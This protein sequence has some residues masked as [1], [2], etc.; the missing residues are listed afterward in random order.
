MT[1]ISVESPSSEVQKGLKGVVACTTSLSYIDGDAGKL[2]YLGY[3]IED[4][5]R[6]ATYEEVAYL[7]WYG[8]LPTAA[9]LADLRARLVAEMPLPQDVLDAIARTPKHA[10]PITVLRTMVSMLS[11]YDPRPDDNSEQENL[12]KAISITARMPM[13]TAAFLRARQGLAPVAPR[14]DLGFTANF[15]YCLNGTVPTPEMVRAI[16]MYLVLLADHGLNA[17][18]FAS[19]VTISTNSDMF[20]AITSAIGTLKGPLHG[21]ANRAA[22]EMIEKLSSPEE[23]RQFI[24]DALARKERIMGFG[25]RVYKT[26]DPRGTLLYDV[27]VDLLESSGEQNLLHICQ[28]IEEEMMKQKGL[29]YNVDF[30]S[31]PVLDKTGFP[32]D[33]FVDVFAIS[34]GAGWTAHVIEFMRDPA[35]MR[36]RAKY[37]GPM[38]A[39]WVPIE[40]RR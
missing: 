24:T 21:G 30:Y 7:L 17:S 6:H 19:I 38:A 15:L 34:R 31:A 40:E 8:K 9:E 5:A 33:A 37:V 35:L 4:L 3:T 1:K 39:T 27:A 22:Q 23:A 28:A 32:T 13:I 11:S 2:I 12:R 10:T 14:A 29:D 25:H 18:T 26:K 16:D 20:S 36:P